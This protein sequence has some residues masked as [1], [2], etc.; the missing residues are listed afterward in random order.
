MCS[1][2][3]R[4]RFSRGGNKTSLRDLSLLHGFILHYTVAYEL[5]YTPI[6]STHPLT[7]N[8]LPYPFTYIS[9]GILHLVFTVQH[10]AWYCCVYRHTYSHYLESIITNK[11]KPN[12]I[13][14]LVTSSFSWFTLRFLCSF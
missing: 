12:A 8:W 6:Q 10:T 2:R 1:G 5:F 7:T 9:C 4:N 11:S 14:I 3:R 13:N